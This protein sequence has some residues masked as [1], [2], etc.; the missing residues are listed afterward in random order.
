MVFLSMANRIKSE[1]SG[2]NRQNVIEK[3][4][5]LCYTVTISNFACNGMRK[6]PRK[7]KCRIAGILPRKYV[8]ILTLAEIP[9]R[10]GSRKRICLF[11]KSDA[12]G[13]SKQGRLMN[14]LNADR[15]PKLRIPQRRQKYNEQSYQK[16]I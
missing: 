15:L 16:R 6:S 9:C 7:T 1:Q 11:T 3:N 5:I 13:C 12:I 8:P 14:R 4:V 10:L 2:T